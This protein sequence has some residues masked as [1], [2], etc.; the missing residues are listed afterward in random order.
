MPS[1][2]DP[3]AAQASKAPSTLSKE[4]S[5]QIPTEIRQTIA[6]FTVNQYNILL[7]EHRIRSTTDGPS[8]EI[9]I[10][11]NNVREALDVCT[12][13]KSFQAGIRRGCQ[14]NLSGHL[15]FW[16]GDFSPQAC[17]FV[18]IKLATQVTRLN[19]H[20]CPSFYS[21]MEAFKLE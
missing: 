18:K 2:F 21:S 20:I 19:I 1:S 5:G 9:N 4:L 14:E 15:Y 6:A 13:S 16:C 7:I 12:V 10:S 17:A 11:K 8:S 3:L